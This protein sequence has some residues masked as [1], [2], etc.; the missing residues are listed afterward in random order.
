[1]NRNTELFNSQAVRREEEEMNYRNPRREDERKRK[2]A[3]EE[4]L[5]I[6]KKLQIRPETNKW[7]FN[8][9]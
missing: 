5:K 1:M 9:K 7:K 3:F 2:E 6:A 4:E 8:E